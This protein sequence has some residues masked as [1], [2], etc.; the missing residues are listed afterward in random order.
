MKIAMIVHAY[1]FKDARVR[2]YA[3]SLA[4]QGDEVDVIC[5]REGNEAIFE[6]HLGVNIYRINMSRRRGG[7][8]SYFVEYF[9]AFIGFFCKLNTLNFKGHRYQLIHVHNF[10]NFLVFAA[11]IQKFLGAKILLDIHD[12]MPELFC[13]KYKIN[14][15]HPLIKLL[16]IE[17]RISI[18]YADYILTA[19]HAF[20][21]LLVQRSCPNKKIRVILNTPDAR[22]WS[23]DFEEM[24]LRSDSQRF[25]ILY[26]GTLA[27]RYGL[28]TVLQAVESIKKNGIIPKITLSVIP[29]IKN[30]GR[31]VQQLL[32][33][34]YKLC[35]DDNFELL[36][37]VPL[38][39]MPDVIRRADLSVYTPLPDMHMG[40]ALSL[41][42][43]EIIAIGRPLVTSRLPVLQRYFGEDTLFMFEP[44]NVKDCA[45]KIVEVYC[46]PGEAKS[47][48]KKAQ[49]ALKEFDWETQQSFYFEVIDEVLNRSG[50]VKSLGQCVTSPSFRMQ[51]KKLLRYTTSF[52][53]YYTGLALAWHWASARRGVR[54][55]AYHGVELV[56]SNS[57]AV[58]LSNFENQMQYLKNEFNVISLPQ[59]LNI[60]VNG[61]S[62]PSDTVILTFDDGFQNFF[63]VAYP[64]LKKHQLPATCFVIT[65]K[66]VST[67]VDFMHWAELQELV[68]DGLVN[69]GSHTVFH[70]SVSS[71]DDSEL[72]WEIGRSKYILEKGLGV[73]VQFFSYPYGTTRDYNLHCIEVISHFGYRLACTSVNGPNWKCTKPFKLRRT[74]IEW[75]DNFPT[76]K[77]ILKGAMDIW[78]LADYCLAFL[79]KK[80]E[81]NFSSAPKRE[82]SA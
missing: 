80:G 49:V 32:Q 70:R 22:F 56:P 55:L 73:A 18:I 10:P 81:L 13:S 74:K 36:E 72:N 47:R 65:S 58:S 52:L 26:V 20:R 6:T 76:F 68:K 12:P 79:Q 63:E 3:E 64:I 41:K 43:P 4:R 16:Y 45:A 75:G 48:V 42:I 37:S 19:N 14:K 35:L 28:G 11:A 67:D 25:N 33:E 69:I 50:S 24:R 38:D 29:K 82:D 62:F 17:E 31:Y 27:E 21:D 15:R 9:L 40:I 46:N 8:M 57:Y 53:T 77:K 44:G 5:L 34:V 51:L 59:Y 7:M 2:R 78:V 30:E 1:Y 66:V 39:E 23:G 71:L 60:L 54:I 61:E